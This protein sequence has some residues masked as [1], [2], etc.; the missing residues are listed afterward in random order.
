M[1]IDA[2]L[3]VVAIAFCMEFYTVFGFIVEGIEIIDSIA[4]QNV[5]KGNRPIEDVKFSVEVLK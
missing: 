1:N 3:S 5:A 4:A 2:I